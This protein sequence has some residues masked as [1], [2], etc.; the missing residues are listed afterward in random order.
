MPYLMVKIPRWKLSKFS[1]LIALLIVFVQSNAQDSNA[2]QFKKLNNI[3]QFSIDRY[4]NIF[5]VNKDQDV[6]KKG[7][8]LH[9][10]S[11]HKRKT[12]THIEAWNSL[13]IFL[14]N[15]V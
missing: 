9:I 15:Q 12:V 5:F 10:Y 3:E 6:R 14:F 8:S 2:Y 13:K 7:D 4:N 1:F 11:S